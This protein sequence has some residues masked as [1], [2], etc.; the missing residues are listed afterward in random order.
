MINKQRL[1]STFMDYV[2]IDSETKNEKAM[3]E[4]IIKDLES[5]GLKTFTDQAGKKL[6]SNMDN[7]YCFLPGTNNQDA[8]LFSAHMDTVTPGIGIVPYVDGNYV[9]SKGNTILGADDKAGVVSILE[10]IRTIKENNLPHRPIEIVFSIGEEGGVN[11]AKQIE[12][13]KLTAK[14]G[15]VLDSGGSPGNIVIEAPGQNRIHAKVIGKASHAGGCPEAG[16]SA[17]M[18]AAEAVS[19]MKLLRVDN[20]TTANIGTFKAEGPT[21]IV[22]PL[23]EFEAE[24]RSRCNDKLEA[25][26]NHMIDCLKKACD[27]YG[28]QLEYT[29]EECYQSYAFDYNDEYVNTIADICTKLG[30]EVMKIPSGG[31]S[32]ANVYNKN[33]VK[34]IVIGCGMELVHTVDE[35][36]NINDFENAAKV[37]LEL[38][39]K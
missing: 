25:Q 24:A 29:L 22:S 2:Q 1:L 15:V 10:A 32:D 21:N 35:Q 39:T 26:T 31:G 18:V 17:I 12:F 13:S 27:K 8:M 16:I 6:N 7:I 30:L 11:G 19:N 5:L 14:K 34:T 23:V 28:S 4:R 3:G 36:L 33:G 9:K 38:M 37:V 20:E